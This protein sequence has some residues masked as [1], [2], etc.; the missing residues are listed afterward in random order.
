MNLEALDA[1]F[2]GIGYAVTSLDETDSANNH[3]ETR[4]N[5][6][7]R[8][9]PIC[10]KSKILQ[11]LGGYGIQII[12]FDLNVDRNFSPVGTIGS[13]AVTYIQGMEE[14]SL[15]I[16]CY[17]DSIPRNVPQPKPVPTPDNNPSFDLGGAL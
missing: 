2:G 1:I 13:K 3:S 15:S 8:S 12:K 6:I 17:T 11:H 16:C 5:A 10:D 14:V 7:G 4:I 9:N